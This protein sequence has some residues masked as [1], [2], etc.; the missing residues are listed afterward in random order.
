[1]NRRMNGPSEQ[2][3]MAS[4]L[5]FS[6]FRQIPSARGL[7]VE[8]QPLGIARRERS[9]GGAAMHRR[10]VACLPGGMGWPLGRIRGRVSRPWTKSIAQA[11][12]PVGSRRAHAVSPSWPDPVFQAITHR[13]WI[14]RFTDEVPRRS[15]ACGGITAGHKLNTKSQPHAA[16]TGTAS[17]RPRPQGCQQRQSRQ[18]EGRLADRPHT[19]R[20]NLRVPRSGP[21]FMG[22]VSPLLPAT[23]WPGG[24]SSCSGKGLLRNRPPRPRLGLHGDTS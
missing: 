6:I 19:E 20:Q 11:R 23:K 8:V 17:P 13:T 16:A 1:M 12:W 15:R 10:E 4:G 2:L 3:R 18:G 22:P 24:T 14:V 7:K 9:Q 21:R 5:L